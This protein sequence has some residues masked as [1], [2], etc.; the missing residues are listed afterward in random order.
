MALTKYDNLWIG[1]GENLQKTAW[2][3]PSL[4]GGP[5]KKTGIVK[6]CW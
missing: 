5:E 2:L 4:L 6:L 1:L 3:L